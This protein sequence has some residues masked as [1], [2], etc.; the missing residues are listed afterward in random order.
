MAPRNSY[1]IFML[2][3][4]LDCIYLEFFLSFKGGLGERRTI[5]YLVS[6]SRLRGVSLRVA[7]RYRDF[8]IYFAPKSPLQRRHHELVFETR[9]KDFIDYRR[10]FSYQISSME[11]VICDALIR[12]PK[13]A[14][15]PAER[16]WYIPGI[17]V[18]H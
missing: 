14:F 7:T 15:H 1:L 4:F 11:H 6:K 2:N 17:H 8:R 3:V 5:L 12:A 9:P 10:C 16:H 18:L 13:T